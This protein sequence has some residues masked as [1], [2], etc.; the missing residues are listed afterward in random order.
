MG[1]VELL[2]I[3]EQSDN[4]RY[5]TALRQTARLFPEAISIFHSPETAE[6]KEWKKKCESKGDICYNRHLPIGKCY[7]LTKTFNA[8]AED[9]FQHHWNEIEDTPS[10]NPQVHAVEKVVSL[11]PTA[12]IIHYSTSDVVVV[13]G[14]DFVVCRMWRRIE[15]EWFVVAASFE[16]DIPVWPKKKRGQANIVA[17]CFRQKKGDPETAIVDYLVSVDFPGTSIPKAVLSKNIA[18]MLVADARYAEKHLAERKAKK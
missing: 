6:R 12:D 14:R 16:N 17:G 11:S 10:W 7:L 5:S 1:S 15:D 9:I 3:V 13:K 18:E 4:P 2:G 8:A